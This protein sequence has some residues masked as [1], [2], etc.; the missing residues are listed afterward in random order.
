MDPFINLTPEHRKKLLEFYEFGR[1]I[2]PHLLLLIYN[3]NVSV[4][5]RELEARR[6][7]AAVGE[8]SGAQGELSTQR[9]VNTGAFFCISHIMFF[10]SR[11]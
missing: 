5:S 7:N 2:I 4:R 8:M 6:E 3:M 9:A 1:F 11:S 10:I